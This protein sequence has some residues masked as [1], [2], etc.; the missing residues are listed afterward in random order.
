MA[1]IGFLRIVAT[2]GRNQIVLKTYIPET[3]DILRKQNAHHLFGTTLGPPVLVIQIGI[4]RSSVVPAPFFRPLKKTA[5]TL[6]KQKTTGNRKFRN[7][8]RHPGRPQVAQLHVGH[9]STI[10]GTVY[11]KTGAQG[12]RYQTVGT[13]TQIKQLPGTNLMRYLR[14]G[15]SRWSIR[16]S[17]GS[18]AP[19]DGPFP[20]V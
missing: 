5:Q 3:V 16:S 7:H 9:S 11:L 15:R 4:R 20:A 2:Y 6:C 17:G 10:G 8:G 12:I 13:G 19:A 14:T 18:S 1:T